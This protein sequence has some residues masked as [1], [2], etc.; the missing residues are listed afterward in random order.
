MKRVVRL[1]AVAGLA[2]GLVL[3]TMA[4]TSAAPS[5]GVE[6]PASVASASAASVA[7]ASAAPRSRFN[8][9]A[10]F[11]REFVRRGDSD[12]SVYDIDHVRELQY[13]LRWAGVYG[14][15]V[16]G[17]FGDQTTGAVKRFQRRSNLRVTGTANFE[18]WAK[19]IRKTIQAR[20][21][22]P[23]RCKVRRVKWH[24]CYDRA[25]HQVTLWRHD[26]L[27]NSW[28]VRGGSYDAQTRL[29]NNFV[30]SRDKDHVSGIFGSPMPYSQFFDGGQA[31]HGSSTMI[32]P[33]EGHSHGCVNMYNE[34]ARQLWKLTTRAPMSE[35]KVTVYGE[36]S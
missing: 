2:A 17:Y 25:T 23:A 24:A 1:T 36:W 13:R 35:M 21:D 22:I 3:S 8:P 9:R 32:D 14:G 12:T 30:F 34:D 20:G 18:T 10:R 11:A 26:E 15:P 27:W 16:T 19:L 6:A 31:L 28:L 4:A 5:A 29:G 33:F 7:S